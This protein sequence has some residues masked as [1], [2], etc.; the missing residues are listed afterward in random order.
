MVGVCEGFLA[1]GGIIY[2]SILPLAGF[3]ALITIIAIVIAYYIGTFIDNPKVTVWAKTEI[4]QVFISVL[5]V[6]IIIAGMQSFCAIDSGAIKE[7]VGSKNNIK[8]NIFDE[9]ESYLVNTTSYGHYAMGVTRYYLSAYAIFIYR[10]TFSCDVWGL[11]CLFGG[12]GTSYSSLANYGGKYGSL[13]M[14]FGS[15]V[16]YFL[17][18]ANMLFIL[19]FTYKGFILFFLPLA[20][21][22]RSLPYLRSLGSV[23]IAICISFFLVYPLVLSVFSVAT[24]NLFYN[25]I[26]LKEEKFESKSGLSELFYGSVLGTVGTSVYTNDNVLKEDLFVNGKDDYIEV[27]KII[28]T[29]FVISFVLP[30]LALAITLASI[31]YFGR[32][33]GEDVDL[34]RLSQLV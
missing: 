23:L 22:I 25:P 14:L 20:I 4:V 21:I 10:Y 26:F 29:A 18:S 7:I 31:R 17:T 12:S 3:A 16:L 30:S 33:Y 24:D 34:S 27:L 11:G 9:A 15:T 6:I 32:L 1:G 13:N 2:N 19:L 8:G 28:A 5:A